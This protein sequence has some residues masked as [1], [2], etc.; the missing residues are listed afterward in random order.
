MANKTG[1]LQHV[2]IVAGG[3]GN[4]MNSEIPKQFMLLNGLPLIMHSIN[5]FYNYN[6]NISIVLVLP[7][8]HFNTWDKLKSEHSLTIPHLIAPGGETRFH[9]VK[10]GLNFIPANGIVGV[11]DA[12]RPL[13]G[14]DTIARCYESADKSGSGIPF[15]LPNDSIRIQKNGK[16]KA[17]DRN[18]ICLIQTPQC[19]NTKQLKQ[20]YLSRYSK[21]FT[22]DASVFEKSGGHIVLVEGNTENIKITKPSDLSIA[23]AYG[24]F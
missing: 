19:F 14:E 6:N 13:V 4:R 9:S 20:A 21:K 10:N 3:S 7:K 16:S 11:H 23:K 2:I 24:Q 15:I 12:A 8:T 18:K 5:A 22:D 1:N 17:L